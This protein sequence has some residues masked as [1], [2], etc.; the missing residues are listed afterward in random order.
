L[1]YVLKEAADDALL[2]AIRLVGA[3]GTY[4]NPGVAV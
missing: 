1:G 3:G 4:L 2:A